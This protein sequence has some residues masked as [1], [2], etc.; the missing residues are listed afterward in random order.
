MNPTR[1]PSLRRLLAAL[2]VEP[3]VVARQYGDDR[4]AGTTEARGLFRGRYLVVSRSSC[5]VN[6]WWA[7]TDKAE[8]PATYAQV[9]RAL[10]DKQDLDALFATLTGEPDPRTGPFTCYA[11]L[12]RLSWLFWGV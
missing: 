2:G 9:D 5:D 3:L 11:K 6:A 8:G 12:S 7:D 4:T 1:P 10:G